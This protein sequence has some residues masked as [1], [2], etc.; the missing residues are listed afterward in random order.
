MTFEISS[1]VI[2]TPQKVYL[3]GTPGVGKTQLCSHI[4]NALVLD[5]EKGSLNFDVKRI[6]NVT[7]FDEFRKFIAW[8]TKEK[9]ETLV[10]DSFTKIEQMITN[11]VLETNGWPNLEKPGYGKGYEV[12]KQEFMRFI[13]ACN[14]LVENGKNVVIVGHSTVKPFMDPMGEQYDRF[15]PDCQ[16]QILPIL[17]SQMDSLFFYSW[18]KIIVEAEKGDRHI[19]KGSGDREIFTVERPAF[20]AKSRQ[21]MEVSYLNPN[22]EFWKC[23]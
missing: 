3:Y 16:K 8:F 14:F 12:L 15:Q 18:R 1:G 4:P 11:Y 10:I 5:L 22:K 17:I 2:K 21:Q 9:Y 7:T 13:S 19:A 23:L 20:I 6:L